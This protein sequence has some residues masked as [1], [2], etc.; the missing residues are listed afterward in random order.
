MQLTGKQKR[1]LRARGHSLKPLVW[2]GKNGIAGN[3]L[4]QLEEVLTGHE[5]IKVKLLEGCP[6]SVSECADLRD[7]RCQGQ[8]S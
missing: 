3:V 6:L 7:S 2:I 1:F 8:G 5:L 4:K